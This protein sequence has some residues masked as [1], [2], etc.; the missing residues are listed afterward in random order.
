M[1]QGQ[2]NGMLSEDQKQYYVSYD[3]DMFVSTLCEVNSLK[4]NI[5]CATDLIAITYV[6]MLILT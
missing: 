3:E 1:T 6:C 2:K 4:Y 5:I